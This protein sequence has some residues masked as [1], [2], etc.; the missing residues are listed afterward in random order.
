MKYG[1]SMENIQP[2]NIKV[3]NPEIIESQIWKLTNCDIKP[4]DPA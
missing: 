1:V 3:K 2:F 4:K